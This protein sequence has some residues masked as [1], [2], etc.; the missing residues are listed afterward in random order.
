MLCQNNVHTQCVWCVGFWKWNC[1]IC[2]WPVSLSEFGESLNKIFKSQKGNHRSVISSFAQSCPTLC[3]PM[4]CN[5]PGLPVHHQLPEL[6]QTHVHTVSESI[7]PFPPL[8][9]PSPHTFNLSQHQGLFQWVS[10]LHQVAEGLEFQ[11]QNQSFQWIFRT[12]FF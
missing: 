2:E 11:L 12:D 4:D 8:L 9:S 7:Q 5:S 6:A 1:V 10:S 3:N